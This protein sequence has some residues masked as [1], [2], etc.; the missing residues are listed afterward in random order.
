LGLHEAVRRARELVF[1]SNFAQGLFMR[2]V[3]C[4]KYG[5]PSSLTIEDLPMPIPGPDQVGISIHASGINFADQL[6]I[7]GKTHQELD[8]PFT[9]GLEAAGVV[10]TVGANVSHIKVGQRVMGSGISGG[11]A[12]EGVFNGDQVI[13]IPDSMPFTVAAGFFIASI[14]SHYALVGRANLQP[15]E[16]LLVLGAAGGCGLTAVEI[17]KAAGARVVAAAS[18]EAKLAIAKDHGADVCYRYAPGPLDSGAQ[19]AF[20]GDLKALLGSSDGFDVIYDAVG[21]S[22][23]EPAFRTIARR[24]R[25]LIIGFTAGVPSLPMDV[26]LGKNCDILGV[27]GNRVRGEEDTYIRTEQAQ[28]DVIRLYER[29]ALRP[30]IGVVYPLEGFAEA[31]HELGARRA[32]GKVI[33]AVRP[34]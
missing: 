21:G 28:R 2:A 27:T 14:T 9:P 30:H 34:Q 31:M 33:L 12:E 19:R 6:L 26:A 18:S 24:G 32:M 3:V 23:A 1:T 17:G 10:R 15:N 11:Y 16:T 25:Y 5:P 13:P 8:P 7:E 22:Y 20:R 4:R 29:G